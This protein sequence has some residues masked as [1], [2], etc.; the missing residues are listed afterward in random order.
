MPLRSAIVGALLSLIAT[1]ALG[2][3]PPATTEDELLVGSTSQ[4]LAPD[5]RIHTDG[6]VTQR[7]CFNWSC[8]SRQRLTFTRADM[9]EVARQMA[10]CPGNGW[11]TRVQR[12]RIG[13][14]QMEL[15]AQKY[16]PLLAND[17]A[18][19]KVDRDHQ[20][21][22]D[23]VDN[24]SNTT[25]YL[26]VLGNLGLL[27]GWSV[28]TQQVRDRFSFQVHW[29][30]I[31]VDR[32]GAGSWA[33]DSWFRPNGYLPYVMPAAAWSSSRIAWQPPFAALNP[34]P[35]FSSELCGV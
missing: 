35:R 15:L 13:I 3:T 2:V 31:V 27:P 19:N 25:S 23:C 26:H 22:M 1:T 6:S 9:T 4:P 28:A 33:V 29:T 32:R 10:Q 14:W 17:M 18:I 5:Y 8:A 24:A 7:I 16:Q 21:R 12:L 20:G 11:H 34:S 30:A